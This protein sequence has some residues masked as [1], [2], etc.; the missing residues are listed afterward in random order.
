MLIGGRRAALGLEV[1]AWRLSAHRCPP[2]GG[3]QRCRRGAAATAQRAL[4]PEAAAFAYEPIFQPDACAEEVPYRRLAGLS[5]GLHLEHLRDG[6][7]V[8]HVEPWVLSSLAQEA[9]SDVNHL[10]RPAHL[11]QLRSILEDPEASANDKLVARELLKNAVV[12][13]GRRL[14]SCQDT[15]TA[16]IVANRGHLLM[17]DGRDSEHLSRGVYDAYVQGNLRYSQMAPL[18]MFQEAN[19]KNNLPAQID[20]SMGNGSIYDLLFIAKG[21][22]SANKTKLLQKTKAILRED[23][24]LEFVEQE[25]KALGTA[26]CPP[27][28]LSIVVGGLSPDMNMKAVKLL[29]SRQLDGLPREGSPAGRAIR[30]PEWEAR[31]RELCQGLGIGAQFGGKY[32]VHDV[33]VARL[34]RHG[35]SCPVGIGVSC[36]ADRQARAKI[37]EDGVFL[38]QLE[39][40]PEAYL[41]VEERDLSSE[42]H[43][44]DLDACPREELAKY[45]VATRLLLTGTMLVARDIAHAQIKARLDSGS[46]LPQYLKDHPLFYAGPSKTPE[47]LPSGSFGPTSAVRMDPYVE[48]FQRHGGSLIMIGKG[49]RTSVVTKSCKK[50]GGFYLGTIGGMAAQLT[51]S[52]IRSVEIL[53][54]PEL[55]MEAVFRVEVQDFPAFIIVDDKGNDFFSKGS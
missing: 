17:T 52:C 55:G 1:R 5:E 39:Q 8:L 11:A 21:G 34:P 29:A 30:A 44:V 54:M 2:R 41:P 49:N 48:E 20:I 13:A 25:L 38:E 18:G 19:T 33:R 14:P 50:H 36:S 37:C 51:S 27:Y 9:M 23:A 35:G 10:F 53:D 6:R 47:G 24:F 15:G 4:T 45:P 40:E 7:S 16:T 46:P 42:V 31:I 28:H 32:F 22:G 43:R 26:A 12:A 3:L